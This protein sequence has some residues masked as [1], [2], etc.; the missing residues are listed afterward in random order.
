MAANSEQIRLV[1]TA[2][3]EQTVRDVQ[4]GM[5]A[6]GVNAS[7]RTRASVRVEHYD[8]GVRL[9]AGGDNTAPFPTIEVGRIGG[10]VPRGFTDILEQWSRDKGL[11]FETESRRRSFAY[12][13]GRKIAREGTERSR[14]PQD[15]YSTIVRNAANRLAKQLS[16]VIVQSAAHDI[17][18]IAKDFGK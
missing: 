15:V 6:A 11:A 7:G 17:E 1:V 12:L 18:D 14:Q 4:V 13:L 5:D 10:A 9:L 2:A 8:K 16:E 3:L